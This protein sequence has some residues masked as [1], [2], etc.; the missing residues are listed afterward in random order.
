MP[1]NLVVRWELNLSETPINKFPNNLVAKGYIDLS[2]SL[3][4]S[5][6]DNLVFYDSLDL[7]ETSIKE[8]PKNLFVESSLYL[9]KTK[10]KEIPSDLT[11]GWDLD[12]RDTSIEELPNNLVVGRSLDLRKTSIKKLPENLVVGGDLYLNDTAIKELPSS[13]R[14]GGLVYMDYDVP[15]YTSLKDGE[16]E[17]GRYLYAQGILTHIKKVRKFHQYTFYI[18]KAKGYNVISDGK[19]Y[20]YGRTLR[21]GIDNLEFKAILNRGTDQFKNLTLDS[22][23][24]FNKAIAMYCSITGSTKNGTEHFF[25]NLNEAKD[26]Y[27]IKEII[28]LTKGQYGAETFE[29]FFT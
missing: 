14:V 21:K 9:R 13:L 5:L 12:L 4:Q 22:E 29:R 23:V 7:K 18:G 11:V 20:S 10:I 2:K 24:T 3:I 17:P 27:T 6:P 16:Y 8:L 19:I 1:D 26:T 28:E 15:S 25:R